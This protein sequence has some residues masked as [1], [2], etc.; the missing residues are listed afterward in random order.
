MRPDFLSGAVDEFHPFQG[1]EN[2]ARNVGVSRCWSDRLRRPSISD[3]HRLGGFVHDRPTMV[4]YT[5]SSIVSVTKREKLSQLEL[6]QDA[7][8]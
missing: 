8:M 6:L 7:L 4:A 5:I 2:V 3:T 1:Q